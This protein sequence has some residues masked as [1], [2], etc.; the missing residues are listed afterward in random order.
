MS[1]SKENTNDKWGES[2]ELF[3]G[4]KEKTKF[5]PETGRFESIIYKE[6]SNVHFH[7]WLNP[8]KGEASSRINSNDYKK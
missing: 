1:W 5:N 3:P 8:S 6:G 7:N 4:V 2:K